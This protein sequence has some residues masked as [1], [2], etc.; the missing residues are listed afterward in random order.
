MTVVQAQ[1]DEDGGIHIQWFDTKEHN[2][3]GGTY[4]TS[5]ITKEAQEELEH[6][7]Y[8]AKEL[9]QDVEE[10]LDHWLQSRR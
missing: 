1:F 8:Y 9:R 5:Y 4:L 3:N 7:G 10:L 6:V 2:R